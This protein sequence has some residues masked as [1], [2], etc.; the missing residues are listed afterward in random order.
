MTTRGIW[1]CLCFM[2]AL[3]N[4][5]R[6]ARRFALRCYWDYNNYMSTTWSFIMSR[7]RLIVAAVAL[8]LI[9]GIVY[10]G[11][12][13]VIYNIVSSVKPGCEA[14]LENLKNTP[15]VFAAAD[16]ET[17]LTPYQM[18]SYQDVQFPSRDDHL[19]IDGWYVPT[20]DADEAQSPAVILVHGL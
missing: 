11:A 20:Q 13:A 2:G 16:M 9:L 3:Y 15:T 18:A 10:L 8:A 7:W 17:D 19:T 5:L 1:I 12:G 4:V 6:Y 14:H